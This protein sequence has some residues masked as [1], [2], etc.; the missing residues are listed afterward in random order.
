MKKIFMY[1]AI[2]LLLAGTLTFAGCEKKSEGQREAASPETEANIVSSPALAVTDTP[3]PSIEPEQKIEKAMKVCDLSKCLGEYSVVRAELTAGEKRSAEL[4]KMPGRKNVS[5]VEVKR[6]RIPKEEMENYK[7]GK[8]NF[9]STPEQCDKALGTPK[10]KTGEERRYSYKSDYEICLSFS[11]KGKMKEMGIYK[12]SREQ[13]KKTYQVG[14]FTM[15][16]CRVIKYNKDYQKE[17]E[18]SLPED[19]IAVAYHAF[20]VDKKR[21]TEPWTAR[22]YKQQKDEWKKLTLCIPKDVY[23]EPGAFGNLGPAEITFEPGRTE[24]E[25]S[26]FMYVSNYRF[27]ENASTIRLPDTVKVIRESSFCQFYN[28]SAEIILN[29]GLEEIEERA[30]QGANCDLPDSVKKI[31]KAALDNWHPVHEFSLPENLQEIGDNA[32]YICA[33]VGANIKEPIYLS[34]SVGKIGIN[35]ITYETLLEDTCGVKVDSKN[36]WFKNDDNGWLYSKDGKTLYFAFCTE[37]KMI[38]PEGLEKIQCRLQLADH[39]TEWQEIV[40]PE[41][42]TRQEYEEFLQSEPEI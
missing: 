34:R 24:I 37:E 35:P 2:F 42:I 9:F 25:P 26:A 17:E 8:V 10:A 6:N 13:A 31:G 29:D 14:D 41:S 22:D 5:Y 40:F 18:V 12:D 39:E 11:K 27:W 20:A 1:P 3:E 16:A 21:F 19:T 33:E 38:L 15:M 36:K 30:L 7:V 28:E 4:G 23:L 32:I